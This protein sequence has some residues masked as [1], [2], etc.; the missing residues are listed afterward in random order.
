MKKSLSA[1]AAIALAVSG[2]GGVY[3]ANTYKAEAAV[4][5][6]HCAVQLSNGVQIAVPNAAQFEACKSAGPKCA[7]GR[8][9]SNIYH[10]T[11]P[12]G[13]AANGYNEICNLSY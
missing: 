6:T 4:V 7:N 1:I 9:Y 2:G 11:N 10:N 5:L 3:F 13:V 12:F 8:P